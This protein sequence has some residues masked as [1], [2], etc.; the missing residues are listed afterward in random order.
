MMAIETLNVTN[1]LKEEKMKIN[2]SALSYWDTGANLSKTFVAA[3]F[4]VRSFRSGGNRNGYLSLRVEF[5]TVESQV[6]PWRRAGSFL[7]MSV[8]IKDFSPSSLATSS[9][10]HPWR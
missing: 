9:P 2:F 3:P 7:M 4:R 8:A 6:L 10:A 1:I 5:S